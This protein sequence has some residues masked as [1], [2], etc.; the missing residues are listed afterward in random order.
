MDDTKPEI[1]RNRIDTYHAKTEP[2]ISFYKGRGVYREIDGL[3][4]IDEVFDNICSVMQ[5]YL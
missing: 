5:E 1:I 3:G 4:T 2:V